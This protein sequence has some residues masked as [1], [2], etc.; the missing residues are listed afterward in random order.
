[1]IIARAPVRI[2][3]AG[4]GTDLPSYYGRFGCELL[5]LAIDRYI[6]VSVGERRD[7]MHSSWLVD[8]ALRWAEAG[9]RAADVFSEVPQSCGL[10]T[11]GAVL[12]AL[13]S[14]VLGTEDAA[15]VADA[16]CRVEIDH[17]GRCVGKQDQYASAFGGLGELIIGT[18]GMAHVNPQSGAMAEALAR[19][20][21]MVYIGGSRDAGA[22]L[23]DQ[24]RS[25]EADDTAVVSGLH[26][27]KQSV[28]VVYS[29]LVRED[30]GT[31]GREF[32]AQW[33]RK[34]ARCPL[35][36]NNAID[37]AM[38]Q[39]IAAGALGA[40]VSGAGGGGFITAVCDS[41]PRVATRLLVQ[42]L[43]VWHVRPSAGGVRHVVSW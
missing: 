9:D 40:K 24:Q 41:A 3:I 35:A 19:H 43:T 23:A 22:I 15:T 38:A 37:A 13:L 5:Y 29:A 10:G 2:G 32:S 17:L 34:V 31:I 8:E 20:L 18:D 26:A 4:G 6:S 36:T 12:V 30:W 16:A 33:A 7:D 14:A 28:R 39:V 21:L 1:M 27:A 25:T 11:S 42:G